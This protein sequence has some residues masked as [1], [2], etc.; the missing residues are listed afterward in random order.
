MT[1]INHILLIRHAKTRSS[2]ERRYAGD[3]DEPLCA[4]GT[5]DAEAFVRGGALP[6]VEAV[7]AGPALRCRQTAQ[8]LF[9]DLSYDLCDLSEI[10]FGVFKGKN[11]DELLGDRQ[12][13]Q[14]LETGCMGD[15]PGGDSVS[16]FKDKCRE[17][18]VGIADAHNEKNTERTLNGNT[19]IRQNGGD[20]PANTRSGSSPP[21]NTRSGDGPPVITRSGGVLALVIHGG[22]IMA[23]LEQLA[24]PKRDFY[25][26]SVPNCGYYLCSYE[27]GALNIIGKG[28]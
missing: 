1:V 19:A 13:E 16:A 12:Y 4:E 17:T 10:D 7:M 5:R 9:P 8:L 21:A 18:F 27:N 23:I 25:D 24:M 26:Y 2:V 15:I 22:N 14:W 6:R 3:P 28:P 20:P 11:A